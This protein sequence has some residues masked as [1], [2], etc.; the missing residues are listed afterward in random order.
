VCIDLGRGAGV[1]VLEEV[2]E[3]VDGQWG[4]VNFGCEGFK[5]SGSWLALIRTYAW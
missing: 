3:V 4:W 2:G 1:E 5:E